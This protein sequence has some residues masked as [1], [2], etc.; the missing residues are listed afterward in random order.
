MKYEMMIDFR[1]QNCTLLL[2][3]ITF[4]LL[5]KCRKFRCHNFD[6][7]HD[8]IH[9]FTNWVKLRAQIRSAFRPQEL[10]K[11]RRMAASCS[12]EGRSQ[13]STVYCSVFW[14]AFISSILDFVIFVEKNSI[15][16]EFLKCSKYMS[17]QFMMESKIINVKFATRNLAN[18]LPWRNMSKQFMMASKIINAKF[19]K[20]NLAN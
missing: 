8:T 11:L 4:V 12:A 18:Y 3:Y 5:K 1:R 10:R 17:K 16:S 15:W 14:F 9:H 2:L 7:E 13:Q 20:R 6:S 19:A